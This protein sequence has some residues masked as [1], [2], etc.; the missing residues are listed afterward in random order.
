[1]QYFR[2]LVILPK[3]KIYIYIL[4]QE[5]H[6]WIYIQQKWA[7]VYPPKEIYQNIHSI[8]YNSQELEMT[9][10][11]INSRNCQEIPWQSSG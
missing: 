10:M 8:I 6:S 11:S 9:Q 5:F 3:L 4:S 2:K 1:M 7:H